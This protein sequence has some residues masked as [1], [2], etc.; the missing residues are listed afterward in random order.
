MIA[1]GRTDRL[2]AWLGEAGSGAA[3]ALL[4]LRR[5][6]GI[7]GPDFWRSAGREISLR[8]G[9]RLMAV[10]NTT[11]DSFWAGSRSETTDEIRSA[12]DRAVEGGADLIDIGGESTRPGADPIPVQVEIDRVTGAIVEA[13][14]RTGLPVS[15]DTTSAEVAAAALDAGAVIINDISAGLD[16]PEIIS[17]AADREAGLVLMHRQGFS[18]TMQEDPRYNDLMGEIHAFLAERADAVLEQGVAP[19]RIAIDPGLGFGKRRQHNFEIYRRMAE[20]HS[21]GYP[22]VVGPSRKRHISGP[23]DRPAE[24]RLMGTASACAILAWQ[25][26]QIVRVHDVAEMR[27]AL[28]T[29]DE[30]RG[31]V[32]EDRVS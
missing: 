13:I 28:D 32:V 26:A 25:G 20:F 10:I 30:I 3:E 8:E 12:L 22:L 27:L 9:T 31:A 11:P 19:D 24:E 16:D 1:C 5:G 4:A 7:E 6:V 23:A 14:E 18:A 2:L 15:I 17:L 21:F 29:L